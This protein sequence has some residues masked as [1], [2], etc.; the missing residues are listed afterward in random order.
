MIGYQRDT[1]NQGIQMQL[2]FRCAIV[3]RG[4]HD[5]LD[6]PAFP[7]IIL[8]VD[9]DEM[10]KHEVYALAERAIRHAL[11]ARLNYNDVIPT[12][13][14][15]VRENSFV[16]QMSPLVITKVLLH[17][18]CRKRGWSKAQLARQLEI[19]P[20]TAARLLD[21]FH[22]SRSEVLSYAFLAMGK[23]IDSNIDLVQADL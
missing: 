3:R 13:Q 20:T 7:E 23:S 17:L 8:R 9:A 21:L 22:E 2:K 10:K 14:G 18:E 15:E 4:K 1:E 12:V 16:V 5:F 11:Q 6:V 19:T